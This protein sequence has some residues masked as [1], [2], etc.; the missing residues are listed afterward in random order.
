M[1]YAFVKNNSNIKSN[2]LER[3]STDL[4][5]FSGM[6]KAIAIKIGNKIRI[7]L[8][9]PEKVPLNTG[10]KKAGTEKIKYEGLTFFHAI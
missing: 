8:G 3:I 10:R 5:N 9:S 4:L 1:K 2:V 6:V 7:Y